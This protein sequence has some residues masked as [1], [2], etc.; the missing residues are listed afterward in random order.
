MKPSLLLTI[1]CFVC[2]WIGATQ[3]AIQNTFDL[4]EM[5]DLHIAAIE[6]ER[7]PLRRH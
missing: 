7:M 3:H 4:S 2:T 1:M 6:P 5:L